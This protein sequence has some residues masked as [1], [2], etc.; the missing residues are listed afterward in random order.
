MQSPAF[1]KYRAQQVERRYERKTNAIMDGANVKPS[2]LTPSEQAQ[3]AKMAAKRR[4]LLQIRTSTDV[5]WCT[6]TTADAGTDTD[7]DNNQRRKLRSMWYDGF[8]A[9]YPDGTEWRLKHDYF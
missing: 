6:I 5:E 7:S 1:N 8:S 2:N 3:V 9:M 4:L